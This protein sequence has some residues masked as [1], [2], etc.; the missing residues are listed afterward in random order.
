MG[1]VESSEE[2]NVMRRAQHIKKV[3]CDR[4]FTTV[5]QNVPELDEVYPGIFIGDECSARDRTSL[6]QYKITHIVNAA[7][8]RGFGMVNTSAS[9]Y[10]DLNIKYLGIELS[11]LSVSDA[12]RYFY[13]TADFIDEALQKQGKVLVHC[14]MGISRSSTLVLAFLML[15]RN[16]SAVEAVTTVRQHRNIHPNDGFITQLAAL[17]MKLEKLRS[18]SQD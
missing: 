5:S 1:E 9:Y 15:K 10:A 2:G 7:S 17:D 4:L 12:S 6:R 8:G 14:L 18:Q 16:M 13:S 3:L 11:D